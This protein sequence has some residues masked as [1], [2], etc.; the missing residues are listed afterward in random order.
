M[1]VL[2]LKIF[3]FAVFWIYS[4]FIYFFIFYRTSRNVAKIVYSRR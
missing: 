1:T 4:N 2:L 3:I